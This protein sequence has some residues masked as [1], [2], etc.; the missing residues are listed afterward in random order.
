MSFLSSTVLCRLDCVYENNKPKC[1]TSS[2]NSDTSHVFLYIPKKTNIEKLNFFQDEY[3]ET[4]TLTIAFPHNVT[5]I[6]KGFFS[7]AHHLE[8]LWGRGGYIETLD[9]Y[10]FAGATN[11]KILSMAANIINSIDKKTFKEHQYITELYLQ[12]NFIKVLDNDLFVPLKNMKILYLNSNQIQEPPK[13]IFFLNSKLKIV[14]M[15]NNLMNVDLFLCLYYE[16]RVNKTIQCQEII[17]QSYKKENEKITSFQTEFYVSV[18]INIMQLFCV[19]ALIIYLR[20]RVCKIPKDYENVNMH[21]KQQIKEPSIIS[22]TENNIPSKKI[23]KNIKKPPIKELT[24][25]VAEI[26]NESHYESLANYTESKA[27]DSNE[28]MMTYATLDLVKEQ[29]KTP[30]IP[31]EE[32]LYAEINRF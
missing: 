20:A 8:T 28:Y 22:E 17:E 27:P 15:A 12:Q 7:K 2:E 18:T 24:N 1:V 14:N 30:F 10:S 11:I 19:I 16:E 26:S 29:N 23:I 31:R 5:K 6:P 9:G 32:T 3:N 4:K 13:N 25:I 21:Y